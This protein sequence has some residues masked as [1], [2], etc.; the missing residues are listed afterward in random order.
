[1]FYRNKHHRLVSTYVLY[2]IP[3]ALCVKVNYRPQRR[4]QCFGIQPTYQIYCSAS[5]NSHIPVNT[6]GITGQELLVTSLAKY[7]LI[8]NNIT[9]L[10]SSYWLR[11]RKWCI[12][13]FHLCLADSADKRTKPLPAAKPRENNI[14]L[15]SMIQLHFASQI[16]FFIKHFCCSTTTTVSHAVVKVA[17]WHSHYY[18]SNISLKWLVHYM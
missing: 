8:W 11:G 5:G 7:Y 9:P 2:Y 3:H 1:M 14:V 4:E 13:T 18:H 15:L 6:C 16:S 12:L 10:H 17:K